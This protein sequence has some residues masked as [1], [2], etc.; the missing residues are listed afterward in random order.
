MSG[1]TGTEALDGATMPL[2]LLDDD[3]PAL[4]PKLAD[5]Q[6]TLL[7]RYGRVRRVDVGEVL[8]REGDATYDLMVLLE[9]L[10]AVV[11]GTGDA[12]RE[13]VRHRPGDIMADLSILTGERTH[14][15][16]IVRKAGS[17]LVVPAED[18][19]TLL[20]RELSFGDFIL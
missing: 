5:E 16:G 3:D 9:G 14:A 7:G 18:F 2:A 13:L 19:R 12:Q 4:F 20:G 6:L 1:P 10:V 15:A 17:M 8:F 11:V